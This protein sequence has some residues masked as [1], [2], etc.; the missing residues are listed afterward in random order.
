M[1]LFINILKSGA[2]VNF[3]SVILGSG[4]GL[5]LK[6]GIPERLQNAIFTGMAL[7]VMLIG[8]DG[9]LN[10]QNNILVIVISVA[11]GAIIGELINID[12]LVHNLALKIESKVNNGGLNTKISEGFVAATLLFCVGAM[13]IVGAIES[14]VS[15]NNSTLYSKSLIDCISAIPLAA[16][17]G[18]GV[19]FAALPVLLIEGGITALALVL[20]PVLTVEITAN[21]STI[22]SLLIVAL[23]LNMLGITKIKVINFLPAVFLPAFILAVI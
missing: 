7:C 19:T 22:G 9:M 4:I 2:V 10:N 11:I 17:F 16:S 14:G 8:I 18:V 13:T 21:M 20:S 1:D 6:K 15:G 12:R 5:I 3:I 23:S